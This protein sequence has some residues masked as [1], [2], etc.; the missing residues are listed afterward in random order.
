MQLGTSINIDDPP[1]PD[2]LL[3]LG[4]TIVRFV[5]TDNPAHIEVAEW[6]RAHNIDTALV[7]TTE[8]F[9]PFTTSHDIVH[10]NYLW[11]P[12]YLIIGNEPDAS[13]SE[14]GA[15]WI[16]PK[17][18]FQQ[19]LNIA[20][21]T[22]LVPDPQ[23]I[24]GGLVSGLPSYLDNLHFSKYNAVDIHPYAKDDPYPMLSTYY[25]K[26]YKNTKTRFQYLT[27]SEFNTPA[28]NLKYFLNRMDVAG[29]QLACWFHYSYGEFAL[30]DAHKEVFEAYASSI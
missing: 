9:N 15:S 14:E 27:V 17:S 1:Y 21:S 19:L 25:S 11:R 4:F 3:S 5:A 26:L 10:L 6:Y 16:M 13:P 28:N 8:A 23:L 22:S 29:V 24:V 12:S 18:K 2:D 30:T 20:I 7:L